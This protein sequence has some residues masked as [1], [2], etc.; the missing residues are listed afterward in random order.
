MEA[1][2]IP[3]STGI[4]TGMEWATLE[5]PHDVGGE[6]EAWRRVG[7]QKPSWQW[8]DWVPFPFFSFFFF[9]LLIRKLR[10]NKW[11]ALAWPEP[12]ATGV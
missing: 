4:R 11:G 12:G 6:T 1:E 3:I 2:Q 5:W 10:C 8:R 9:F 7:V